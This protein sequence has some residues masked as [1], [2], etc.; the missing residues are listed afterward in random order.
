MGEAEGEASGG[1]VR[2]RW[3]DGVHRFFRRGGEGGSGPVT[4]PL[5][6]SEEPKLYVFLQLAC[7]HNTKEGSGSTGAGA[8]TGAIRSENGT[9]FGNEDGTELAVE[10]GSQAGAQVQVQMQMQ[11]HA[12][13]GGDADWAVLNRTTLMA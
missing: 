3:L 5:M 6:G 10:V 4:L 9:R 1:W 7:G 2:K 13:A 8:G 11:M 12:D